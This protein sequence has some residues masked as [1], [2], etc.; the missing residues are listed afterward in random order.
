MNEADLPGLITQLEARVD[1]FEKGFAR[2]NRIQR[3]SAAQMERRANQSAERLRNVYGKAGDSILAT[4]KKLGPGIAG[5]LIGGLTVGALSGVTNN[6]DQIVT[7]TAQ[8]G[9]EAKRAGVSVRALQEWSYIGR[10]NRIGI[11]QIVDGLK[12]MQLRTDELI[13]TGKGPAAEAFDR[14]GFSSDQLK[15]KLKD[16]SELLLEIIGRMEQL[17]EAARIRI[18]DEIFGGSAGERFVELVGRGERTLRDTIRAA[19]DTGAVL[20]AEVIEKAQELDRR[21]A[22]LQTR[23]GN[24]F[25]RLAV[26]AADASV[27]I[28][29]LRTDI[30]DLFRSHNQAQGLL[31]DGVADALAKDSEAVDEHRDK[32]NLL[33]AEYE[34]LS[35]FANGQSVGLMQA[36]NTL[37]AFDYDAVADQLVFAATE[38][39][40][41]TDA[42]ADG[43]IKADDFEKRMGEAAATAQTALGNIEAVD[44]AEF[45]NVISGVGSL[46]ERLATAAKKAR[47]LR[48]ALP[49]ATAD[50][51]TNEAVYSGRGGDLRTQGGGFDGWG[52]STATSTAPVTSRRPRSAPSNIDFS[53][54]PENGA[55]GRSQSD[56]EREISAIAEETA[57]LRHEAQA[58]AELTGV[59]QNHTNGL[60]LARTKAELLAAAQRSGLADTPELRAQIDA[61]AGQYVAAADSA[62][63]AAE[64]IQE[65]Q[66][67]SRA[68]AESITDVFTGMATGAMT[69]KEAVGQLI[70]QILKLS[71]QKRMLEMAEGAGGIFGGF[72]KILGGGFAAGGYTGHGGKFEPAGVV[73]RGEYVMSK[74]AT[75][76]IGVPQLEAL[77]NAAKR[78]FSAG[79]YAGGRAPLKAGVAG[80]SGAAE[81]AGQVITINA[82]VSVQGGAGTPDQNADLAKR[83]SREMEAIMRGF[84]VD[85]LRRQTRPGNMMSGR[86]R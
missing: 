15:V 81:E 5:G 79:G 17:D 25:K 18:A 59:R 41:L 35:D 48:G 55:G 83:F 84:V 9:D 28:V 73:H 36:A 62:D 3:K 22:A 77:H 43:S 2:A 70:L 40:S 37:R 26:G 4:F 71:F 13:I 69:A 65:V 64:R 16:P 27:K 34:R 7:T 31:G 82:P 8:I 32:I 67:A 61:L 49:G 78:G 56:F 23:V 14:L 30:D 51:R 11:D 50:G 1:K 63:L 45:S 44:R 68:G 58:L 21:F 19:N 38:M 29:T 46:I 80:R 42:L 74:E 85:E 24:F 66:N 76:A 12:E 20:D 52:S 10:Q 53:L 60:E 33:R 6:L 47:E 57:A 75:K 39:R 54:P 86:R 72:L